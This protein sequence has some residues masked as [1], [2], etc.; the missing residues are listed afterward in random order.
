MME[1]MKSVILTLLVVISLVQSYF[2]AYSS[3]K[4]DKVVQTDYVQNEVIGTKAEVDDILFP[5]QVILHSGTNTHTLLPLSQQF[6]RMIYDDFLKRKLYDGFHQSDISSQNLNWDYIRKTSKGIELRFKK[7]IPLHV[8]QQNILQIKQDTTLVDG[9]VSRIW[10]YLVDNSEEVHTYFISDKNSVVFEATKV[11]I[12]ADN[13]RK[14]VALGE[15][16][17]SYHSA[18][19]DYYLPD[20]SITMA[21][22]QA[23]FTEFTADQLKR[24]LFVD[25]SMTRYFV[26]RDLT[27]TYTDGKRALQLKSDSHWMNYSDPISTPVDNSN[28]TKDNLLD[29]IRF[30]NE[31]GGWNGTYIYSQMSSNLDKGP[32]TFFFRQYVNNYPLI[33]L[34]P[35]NFGYIKLMM[36]RGV[37]SSYERSLINI[38][39][40]SIVKKEAILPG[41]KMLDNLIDSYAKKLQISTV[42]PAYQVVVLKGNK[43]DLIPRWAVELQDGT[44]EFIY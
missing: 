24:N 35:N 13:V 10:I 39:N 22:I 31:H 5:E 4:F 21:R 23:A 20:E 42:F 36:Q 25:P 9:M 11:D 40:E 12:S 29:S 30:I 44:N 32:Q 15:Y 3:P 37:V 2:L 34:T 14:Y 1:R 28:D 6:Y 41:G 8:L 17:T 16:L 7:A 18:T 26:E 19:G 38:D 43:V 27:Q 33:G